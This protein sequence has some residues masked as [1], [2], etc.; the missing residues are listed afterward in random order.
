MHAHGWRTV[1]AK[2]VIVSTLSVL[3][4]LAGSCFALTDFDDLQTTRRETFELPFMEPGDLPRFDILFV[5]DRPTQQDETMWDTM[6]GVNLESEG[7]V[8]GG[9]S[10]SAIPPGQSSVELHIGVITSDLGAGFDGFDGCDLHGDDGILQ[11]DVLS[12]ELYGEYDCEPL[13]DEDMFIRVVDGVVQNMGEVFDVNT[14]VQ[15]LILAQMIRTTTCPIKQPLRAVARAISDHRD[16]ANDLFLQEEGGLAVVFISGEDDCSADELSVY[17]PTL[18][19]PYHCFAQGL[20]CVQQ[21]NVYTACTEP[22]GGALMPTADLA[23]LLDAAKGDNAVVVS[24]MA[25]PYDADIGV[26]VDDVPDVGMQIQPSCQTAGGGLEALPAIRLSLLK[27]QFADSSLFQEICAPDS[28]Q[29]FDGVARKLA[30]QTAYRCM[31]K[32]PVDTDD[33][34]PGMQAQ[35]DIVDVVNPGVV[36]Q[37]DRIGPYPECRQSGYGVTCWEMMPEVSC[38]ARYKLVLQRAI[39]DDMESQNYIVEADCL[40]H[41]ED[42]E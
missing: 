29:F 35:C 34:K 13:A 22:V 42:P 30:A 17:D 41:M 19:G 10:Y 28:E 7:Y 15:C 9:L 36:G 16:G 2:R 14:A 39:N 4:L 40:V 31:P 33:S 23:A 8:M 11:S 3:A 24:V 21:D 6:E 27:D 26:L 20:D 38:T 5:V 25:G 18:F 1:M 32:V 12:T 37:E